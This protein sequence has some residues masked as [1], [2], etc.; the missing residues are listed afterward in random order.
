M[1]DAV[2]LGNCVFSGKEVINTATR[3]NSLQPESF[4]LPAVPI[5]GSEEAE[6]KEFIAAWGAGGYFKEST[7]LAEQVQH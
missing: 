5:A 4:S 6:E 3:E 2:T 1:S 7:L